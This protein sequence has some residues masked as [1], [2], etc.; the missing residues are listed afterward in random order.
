MGLAIPLGDFAFI[1]RPPAAPAIRFVDGFDDRPGRWQ[2]WQTWPTTRH[3]L[4]LA[5]AR[6]GD[7]LP[8]TIADIAPETLAP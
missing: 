6:D 7:D 8:V 5:V 2:F 4:S 1:L 3:R